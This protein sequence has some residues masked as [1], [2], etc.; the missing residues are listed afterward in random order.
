MKK[1]VKFKCCGSEH[2]FTRLREFKMCKC[3]KSGYDAGDGYYSRT[4]GDF[5]DLEFVDLEKQDKSTVG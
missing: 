4:L 2:I 5:N 1:L 3:G